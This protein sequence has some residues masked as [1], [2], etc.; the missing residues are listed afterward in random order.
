M[1]HRITRRL[2]SALT[3][4]EKL[5]NAIDDY[6]ADIGMPPPDL[7]ALLKP[8]DELTNATRWNGPYRAFP[9]PVDRWGNAFEYQR[10]AKTR[11]DAVSNG[12]R[13]WS[14]GPDGISGTTDDQFR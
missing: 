1:F 7:A 11:I 10:L 2:S 8:P 3:Q 4:I 6:R 9:L 12:Y 13:V 5:E 14:K